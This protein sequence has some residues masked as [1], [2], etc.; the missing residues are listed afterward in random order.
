[1]TRR[2]YWVYVLASH[3]KTLYVGVTGNLDQRVKAHREGWSAF[4][5]RYRVYRLVY[6]EVFEY[7]W[8]AIAR[9]KRLKR[10]RREKKVALIERH[11]PEWKDLAGRLDEMRDGWLG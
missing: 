10:W 6:F 9:E 2:R 3:A 4:T 8:E 1:M 5:T 7:V 11:N